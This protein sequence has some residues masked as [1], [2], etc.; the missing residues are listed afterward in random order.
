MSKYWVALLL[1]LLLE[2]VA[3]LSALLYQW[4]FIFH[5]F[6]IPYLQMFV[7]QR[8]VG[9]GGGGGGGCR[10]GGK[11]H[12]I[13][14]NPVIAIIAW[15]CSISSAL[16][17]WC[18]FVF[19]SYPLHADICQSRMGWGWEKG[20]ERRMRKY[21]VALLLLLLLECVAFLSAL[22]YSC[23]FI[24]MSY[25]LHADIRQSKVDSGGGGGGVE[26]VVRKMKYWV[27]L[28]LLLLEFV[29]F[30]QPFFIDVHSSSHLIPY[31]L[32]FVSRGWGGGGRGEL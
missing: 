13:L 5:V 23:S 12:D 3:F 30:L 22:P 10:G 4:S 24:F 25:P 11:E 2:F 27:A 31:I 18:S 20:I 21:W 8:W 32:T 26:E 6:N 14:D 16:L 15:I 7:S 1:L 29:A 28:L 19:T 9:L 17:Y